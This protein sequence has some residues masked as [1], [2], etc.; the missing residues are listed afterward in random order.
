M[1]YEWLE[2]IVSILTGAGIRA[3]EEYPAGE[4]VEVLSPAAAVGLG[5]LDCRAGTASFQIRM[6]SPRLLGGWCCQTNAA[7]AAA[8]L[9]A[10]GL[11]CH[12]G[13]MEYLSGNDCF[14]VTLTAVMEVCC[15]EGAWVPGG[16]W[17]YAWNDTAITGVEEFTAERNLDR[18]VIGAFC[19][20][21]PVGVTP[22][23]GGW[24]LKLV[25]KIGREDPE[26]TEPEEPFTLSVVQGIGEVAYGGCYWNSVTRSHSQEGLRIERRGFALSREVK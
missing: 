7:K 11:R 23:Q 12:T 24:N 16:H 18:R 6:L 2:T 5:E 25:Q 8:A 14:C 9:E 15:Q 19:Q 10:E 26:P 3:G 20:G 22:G 4:W 1:G 21:E 13:A 17:R